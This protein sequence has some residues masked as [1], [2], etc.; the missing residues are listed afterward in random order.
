MNCNF[1]FFFLVSENV[2]IQMGES[3][4]GELWYEGDTKE[5][6]WRFFTSR[7][8]QA[9]RIQCLARSP[10]RVWSLMPCQGR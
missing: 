4:G 8:K 9:P 10:A 7:V 5:S 1:F 2:K 3:L 6:H